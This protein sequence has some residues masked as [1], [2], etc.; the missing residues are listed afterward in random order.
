MGADR[1]A[2]SGGRQQGPFPASG[3]RQREERAGSLRQSRIGSI[4]PEFLRRAVDIG[5][6]VMRCRLVVPAAINGSVGIWLA[7]ARNP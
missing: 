5:R 6:L 4:R 3:L 1:P 7:E 2:G